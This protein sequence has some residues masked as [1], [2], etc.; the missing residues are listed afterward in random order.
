MFVVHYLIIDVLS[1]RQMQVDNGEFRDDTPDFGVDSAE[2]RQ[3]PQRF[4]TEQHGQQ[5]QYR[6]SPTGRL[7]V[8]R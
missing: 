7:A 2:S 5:Q 3:L 6:Q 4:R 1:V 8:A